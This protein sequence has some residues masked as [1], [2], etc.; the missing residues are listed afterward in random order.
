MTTSHFSQ[1]WNNSIW[2]KHRFE[3]TPFSGNIVLKLQFSLKQKSRYL[4][5]TASLS[6]FYRGLVQISVLRWARKISKATCPSDCFNVNLEVQLSVTYFPIATGL[7][8]IKLQFWWLHNRI[9]KI[10]VDTKLHALIN[11]EI[12]NKY[13]K[14]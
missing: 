11:E 13:W 7:K 14:K 10:L 6:N 2:R 5:R 12:L 9:F 1:L 4:S 3:T 8:I